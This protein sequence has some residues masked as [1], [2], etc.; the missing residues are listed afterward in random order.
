M[1][2]AREHCNMPYL[3]VLRKANK[4]SWIH[5]RNR[6]NTEIESRLEGHTMPTPTKLGGQDIHQRVSELPYGQPA[7]HTQTHRS[8][9][10]LYIDAQHRSS[11]RILRI[12]NMLNIRK[13]LRILK[14]A[15]N[16]IIGYFSSFIFWNNKAQVIVQNQPLFT[17]VL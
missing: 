5:M 9:P 3:I 1:T 11:T 8:T 13:Y 17:I 10:A 6:I 16:I 2:D 12:L 15:M 14:L 4:Y 7:R